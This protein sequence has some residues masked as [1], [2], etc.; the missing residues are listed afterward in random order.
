[1]VAYRQ[2]THFLHDYIKDNRIPLPACAYNA[3][4]TAFKEKDDFRGYE[5]LE[6]N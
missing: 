4:W 5:N 3:I 6:E 1:M 2:F